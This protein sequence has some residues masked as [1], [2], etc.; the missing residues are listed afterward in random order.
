MCAWSFSDIILFRWIKVDFLKTLQTVRQMVDSP[1][2][3]PF[4]FKATLV[5]NFPI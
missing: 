4:F 1:I 2:F 5:K 3:T